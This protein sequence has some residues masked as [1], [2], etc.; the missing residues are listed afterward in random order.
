M[1]ETSGTLESY[2]SLGRNSRKDYL[3]HQCS[4]AHLPCVAFQNA[5]RRSR[6][7]TSMHSVVDVDVPIDAIMRVDNPEDVPG[8]LFVSIR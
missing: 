2:E 7:G 5:V 1:W 3:S 8:F 6:Q 4:Q